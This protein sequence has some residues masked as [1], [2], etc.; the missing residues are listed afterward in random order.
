MPV[1]GWHARSLPGWHPAGFREC[2]ASGFAVDSWLPD[3][4]RIAGDG[5]RLGRSAALGR[6]AAVWF[7][8]ISLELECP[9]GVEGD[10]GDHLRRRQKFVID[11]S[12]EGMA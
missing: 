11:I 2:Y 1:N 4:W 10:A 3:G 5:D 7:V 6:G 9:F 12:G 8:Q